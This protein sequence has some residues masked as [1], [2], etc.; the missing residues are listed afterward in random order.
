MYVLPTLD[1]CECIVRS[2]LNCCFLGFLT[3]PFNDNLLQTSL[4]HIS[5]SPQFVLPNNS[6]LSLGL[7]RNTLRRDSSGM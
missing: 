4:I 1:A 5:F 2:N 6:N 7:K 3:G